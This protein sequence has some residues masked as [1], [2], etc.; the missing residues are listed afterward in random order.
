MFHSNKRLQ[1]NTILHKTNTQRIDSIDSGLKIYKTTCHESFR[2]YLKNT[3]LHGLKYVGDD[4]I[5]LF[6]R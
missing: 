3:T 2:Q 5:T 6:E 1:G 4:T